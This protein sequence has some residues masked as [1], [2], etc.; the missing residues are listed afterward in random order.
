MI[1]IAKHDKVSNKIK[2]LQQL[3]SNLKE[4]NSGHQSWKTGWYPSDIRPSMPAM[5]VNTWI[6]L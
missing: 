1:E 4:P 5:L 6:V 2:I 3:T